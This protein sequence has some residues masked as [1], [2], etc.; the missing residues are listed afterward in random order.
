MLA[1]RAAFVAVVLLS[2]TLVLLP[3][4]LLA[5]RLD[6]QIRRRVPRLWHRAA[7]FLI[8]LEIRTHGVPDRRRPL[9]LVANHASWVDILVLGALADVVFIAKTDV[10]DWPVFGVLAK[11]QKTIFVAREARTRTG[12]QVDEIAGR[13]KGGE[14]VV[15]FPEG[16]TSDGNRLLEVKTSLF[17]AAAAARA[18]VPGGVVHVQPV[19]IAYTGVH[20][21]PMGRF[22]RPI[23]AWP[24]DIT[25]LP[26]LKGIL[27]AG[28]F[29]VDVDFA[30]AVVFGP[31]ADRK[32]LAARVTAAIRTML[33]E[34]LRGRRS[35]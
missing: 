14:I 25:L 11:L 8:G 22:H 5:L 18:H 1:L 33:S 34:R 24:G 19:S 30:E 9:M 27:E 31:E 12:E 20:G 17:G 4:Q 21:M 28:A 35:A 2:V 16:T 6:W 7:C 15:L 13:L 26:H 10:A 32:A 23:A 3:I 29:E